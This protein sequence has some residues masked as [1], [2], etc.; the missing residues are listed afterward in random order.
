LID[1]T[2]V[3]TRQ[4]TDVLAIEDTH[5]ATALK[6]IRENACR[7]ITVEDIVKTVHV[8][9]SILERRFRKYL[10]KSPQ[11]EI[12]NFQVRKIKEFLKESDYT[13]E[14]IAELTGFEHPE[15][16]YVVF[17]RVTGLTPN[18]YRKKFE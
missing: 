9:R 2:E 15:C 14:H 3:V 18:Q 10:G 16:M 6:L 4:S 8:S 7:G 1:P 12:R 17:K 11:V 13:V 5:V